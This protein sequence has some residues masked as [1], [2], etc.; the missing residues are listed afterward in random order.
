[1]RVGDVDPVRE[2]PYGP[3]ALRQR[4]QAGQMAASDY[5]QDPILLLHFSGRPQ[6]DLRRSAPVVARGPCGGAI[7]SKS[8]QTALI[9]PR[10]V[11]R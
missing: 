11:M 3:A 9:P 2:L 4:K 8:E 6:M 5:R 10:S 1:A 7:R